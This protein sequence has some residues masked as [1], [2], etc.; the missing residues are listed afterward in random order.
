MNGQW[1]VP[2]MIA[3]KYGGVGP[4]WEAITEPDV[5]KEQ[6]PRLSTIIKGQEQYEHTSTASDITG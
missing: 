4:L 6:V 3:F 5:L 2:W 1:G